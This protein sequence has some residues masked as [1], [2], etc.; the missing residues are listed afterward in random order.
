MGNTV[1]VV[2]AYTGSSHSIKQCIVDAEGLG[3]PPCV[4]SMQ[5]SLKPLPPSQ[6]FSRQFTDGDPEV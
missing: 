2:D 6:Y 1:P 5:G 4:T 3:A